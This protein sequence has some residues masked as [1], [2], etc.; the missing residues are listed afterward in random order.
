LSV[1]DRKR[2]GKESGHHEQPWDGA[3]VNGGVTDD[4]NAGHHGEKRCSENNF[5]GPRHA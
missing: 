3:G 5:N 2:D 4:A 1:L